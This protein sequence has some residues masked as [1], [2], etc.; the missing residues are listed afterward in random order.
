[1]QLNMFLLLFHHFH[2]L[3]KNKHGTT[4][5]MGWLNLPHVCGKFDILFLSDRH[6]IRKGEIKLTV[7]SRVCE[8]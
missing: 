8:R 4:W 6:D 5:P 3:K 1:M 2:N 7:A